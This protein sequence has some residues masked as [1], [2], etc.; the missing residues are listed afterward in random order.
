MDLVAPGMWKLPGSGMQPVSPALAGRF[1]TTGP[2]GKSR[3]GVSN[4]NLWM[5]NRTLGKVK[6]QAQGHQVWPGP[7]VFW[8]WTQNSLYYTTL[9]TKDRQ[10]TNKGVNISGRHELVVDRGF[11]H[12]LVPRDMIWQPRTFPRSSWC[13]SQSESCTLLRLGEHLSILLHV[14]F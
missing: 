2:P 5:R 12:I 3:A 7:H 4:P 10:M 11:T 13:C 14:L 8:P 9:L 1:W 6:W